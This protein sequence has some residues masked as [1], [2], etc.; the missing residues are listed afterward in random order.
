MI[1]VRPPAFDVE[2]EDPNHSAI[3]FE[4]EQI[5]YFLRAVR[6]EF[7]EL[8]AQVGA[9]SSI[10]ADAVRLVPVDQEAINLAQLNAMMGIDQPGRLAIQEQETYRV[11]SGQSAE[12][13]EDATIEAP[14]APLAILIETPRGKKPI[15]RGVF[16]ILAFVAVVAIIVLV[17]TQT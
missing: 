2:D 3:A 17:I 6:S 8:K 14:M 4:L 7:N 15:A 5:Q 16:L 13:V 12:R 10:W 1:E 9:T 11:R